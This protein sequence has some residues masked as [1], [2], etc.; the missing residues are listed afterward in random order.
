MTSSH[1]RAFL[2]SPPASL[3]SFHPSLVHIH[4]FSSCHLF[5]LCPSF[6]PSFTSLYL[7]FSPC[8]SPHPFLFSPPFNCF[9]PHPV[10]PSLLASAST[11][12]PS[13]LVH[14]KCLY[15][16]FTSLLLLPSVFFPFPDSF[17]HPGSSFISLSS[18]SV[19]PFCPSL[20]HSA[21]S[22]LPSFLPS[23]F[24]N[25][26]S[27]DGETHSDM[28]AVA[29]FLHNQLQRQKRRGWAGVGVGGRRGEGGATGG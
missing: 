24:S 10:M 15:S 8:F 3:L 22:P 18:S 29:V 2:S 19:L 11:S 27:G 4:L 26:T 9:I 12:I 20:S 13:S 21:Q 7:I 23:F 16:L 17:P 1:L 25:R 28:M 5:P 14:Y 6:F